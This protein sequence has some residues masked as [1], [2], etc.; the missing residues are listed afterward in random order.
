MNAT[1]RKTAYAD[2][3]ATGRVME[4]AAYANLPHSSDALAE[5]IAKAAEYVWARMDHIDGLFEANKAAA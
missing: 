3:A 5:A 4:K 1:D 2:A